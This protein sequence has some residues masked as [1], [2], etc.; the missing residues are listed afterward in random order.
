MIDVSP[1]KEQ[2]GVNK[3]M[4]AASLVEKLLELTILRFW[5]DNKLTQFIPIEM[6]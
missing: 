6:V 1:E 2:T 5:V 3:R 4:V